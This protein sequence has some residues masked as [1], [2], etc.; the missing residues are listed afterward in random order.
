MKIR[1]FFAAPIAAA[2]ML[3]GV[4]ISSASASSTI[5]EPSGTNLSSIS[6]VSGNTYAFQRGGT[7]AGTLAVNKTNVTV[8]EYGSSGEFPIFKHGASD[9][10][11]INVSAS[12][13][14]IDHIRLTGTG[15]DAPPGCGTAKTADYEIGVYASSP[16]TIDDVNAYGNLYAG[17]YLDTGSGGSSVDASVF[18]GIN[19]LNPNSSYD[20]GAFG[21]LIWS[22]G[23]TVNGGQFTDENT[24][25]P[26]YG[27]DGSGIEIYN[28]SNNL[29]ENA[30]GSNDSDFTELGDSAGQASGNTYTD[31]TFTESGSA[32]SEFLVT[33]GS[34][35]SDGPVS[36]TTL[37]G[38]DVD[39]T[40]T[41]DQGI[42]SYDWESGDGTLLT[43]TGNTVDVPNNTA[44][45]T[46]GG[47][48][49]SGNSHTGTW[50]CVAG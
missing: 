4:G 33:R 25:S 45:S 16:V 14:E 13:A 27:F 41:T 37:N 50:N 21:V 5:D 9:G 15:Y 19:A 40:K 47:C 11:D 34:G 28:G 36:D 6:V 48:S 1:L 2:L 17:T 49:A 22:D 38:N 39:L 42:V 29:I 31:N 26:D 8:T 43:L 7:Y 32:P 35:D 3:A 46:D 10:D 44:L 20:S 24:C 30:S 12:G 23:N 18:T